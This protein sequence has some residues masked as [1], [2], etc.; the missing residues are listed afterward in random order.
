MF[1]SF[2]PKWYNYYEV[3]GMGRVTR[4]QTDIFNFIKSCIDQDGCPPTVREICK[5]TGLKSPSTVYTHLVNLRENK[6]IEMPDGKKRSIRI[7]GED[8]GFKAVPILGSI[9]AGDPILAEEHIEGYV[10]VE[11][12]RIKSGEIFCP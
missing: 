3:M 9:A 11:K 5:H 1:V 6:L 10:P 12:S 8:D 4:K 7:L 2:Y